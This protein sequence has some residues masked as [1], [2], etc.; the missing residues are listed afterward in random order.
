VRSV[1]CVFKSGL[2]HIPLLNPNLGQEDQR[3]RILFLD[4]AFDCLQDPIVRLADRPEDADFILIPHPF[5]AVQHDRAYLDTITTLASRLG[6]KVITVAYGDA[7]PVINLPH[8]VAFISSA[9]RYALRSNEIMMPAYAEDLLGAQPFVPRPKG[10][11]PVIGFCGWSDYK[12]LQ[13]RVGTAVG[14]ALAYVEALATFDR[15]HLAKRKGL[16]FRRRALRALQGAPG[17]KTN[18]LIRKSYSGHVKT[19]SLPPEQA[20]REYV[21]N[22][23]DCDM[24]LVVKGDGNYS[25]RF[26]EALSLGRPLLFVDTETPLP[27]EGV[28]P[29]DRFLLSVDMRELPRL[30]KRVRAWWHKTSANDLIEAQYQARRA[31]ADYLRIDKFFTYAFKNL[32]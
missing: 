1:Y 31:F 5:A 10:A 26:Y 18:F 2:P 11:Q 4:R 16:T 14:N 12:N 29:Y 22:L 25:Y 9:Y 27:L 8:S 30:P 20:R 15:R 32:L 19:I 13:N 3:S 23:R 21:D 17:L 6:K 24:A 28:V 7:P